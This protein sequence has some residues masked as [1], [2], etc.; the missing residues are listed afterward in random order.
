[1]GGRTVHVRTKDKRTFAGLRPG[2]VL[3]KILFIE[4]TYRSV[5]VKKFLQYLEVSQFKLNRTLSISF[6]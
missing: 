1:M 4:G 3:L 6:K 2:P 5:L